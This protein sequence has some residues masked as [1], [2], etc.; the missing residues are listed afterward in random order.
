MG[1]YG[2]HYGV[3][4]D[5][6]PGYC[7]ASRNHQHC[8]GYPIAAICPFCGQ[9]QSFIVDTIKRLV[10]QENSEAITA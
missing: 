6:L 2:G 1:A 7:P 8:V 4:S 5:P 3:N 10:A 9:V